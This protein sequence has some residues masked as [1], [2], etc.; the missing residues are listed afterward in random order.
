MEPYR[1]RGASN[2]QTVL[3][4][5]PSTRRPRLRRGL[6]QQR[7]IVLGYLKRRMF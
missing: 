2:T 5:I 7:R 4:L 6:L 3:P 1:L